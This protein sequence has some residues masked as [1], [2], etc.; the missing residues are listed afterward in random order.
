MNGYQPDMSKGDAAIAMTALTGLKS[1]TKKPG[2]RE[3]MSECALPSSIQDELTR[4]GN[5]WQCQ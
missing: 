2:T 3:D 1:D 4:S 5:V